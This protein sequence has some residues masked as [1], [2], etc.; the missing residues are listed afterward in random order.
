MNKVLL[1]GR[2]TRDPELRSLPSRAS[3]SRRSRSRRTSSAAATT[4]GPSTTPASRGTAWPRSPASSCRRA[5]WSTSRAGSRP[6]SGTTTPESAT[7]RPRSSSRR[8]RCCRGRSKKEYAK[9]AQ[10]VAEAPDGA[11]AAERRGR[12]ERPRGRRRHVIRRAA[13]L[14]PRPRRPIRTGQLVRREY[15]AAMPDFV[16]CVE[17][18]RPGGRDPRVRDPD[19]APRRAARRRPLAGGG[20]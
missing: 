12:R 9:E 3:T 8:S 5:S 4:S 1:V 15:R 2:L 14:I 11:P 19:A 18:D 13:G 17:P 6:V 16:V 20:P 10:A 7:G